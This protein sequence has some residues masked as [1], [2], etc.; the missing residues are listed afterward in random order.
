[1]TTKKDRKKQMEKLKEER[2]LQMQL[3]KIVR[4][5]ALIRGAIV[6]RH[7]IK[8]IKQSYRAVRLAADS[9][10]SRYIDGIFIPDIL[11]EIVTLNRMT[12]T[13]DLYSPQTQVL[14][15][16]RNSLVTSVVKSQTE[17]VAKQTLALFVD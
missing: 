1:M 11:L 16:I 7:K 9:L 5:Q 2:E 15:E 8:H 12:E 4:I 13:F 17:G 10:I 14:M 3:H 6:R